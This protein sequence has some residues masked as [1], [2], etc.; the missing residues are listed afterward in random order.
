MCVGA[1]V[2][3]PWGGGGCVPGRIGPGGAAAAVALAVGAELAV[4]G[5]L[6]ARLAAIR[7]GPG[8][9]GIRGGSAGSMGGALCGEVC[10]CSMGC[11]MPQFA[12]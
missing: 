3:A 5:Q 10:A 12:W 1:R 9:A 4:V 6:P 8:R 2:C 7:A 11:A